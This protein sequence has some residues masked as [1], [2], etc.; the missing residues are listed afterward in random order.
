MVP[1]AGC[2]DGGSF[3]PVAGVCVALKRKEKAMPTSPQPGKSSNNASR[4]FIDAWSWV[5]LMGLILKI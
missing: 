1:D 2:I 4:C 5:M 3:D